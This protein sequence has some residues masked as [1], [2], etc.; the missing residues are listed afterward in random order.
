MELSELVK[1]EEKAVKKPKNQV[2]DTDYN[3]LLDEVKK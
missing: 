1:K 2:Y 3:Y